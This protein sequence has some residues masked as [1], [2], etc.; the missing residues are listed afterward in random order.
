LDLATKEPGNEAPKWFP[1]GHDAWAFA[2]QTLDHRRVFK[3]DKTQEY[4]IEAHLYDFHEKPQ[5]KEK[6][7]QFLVDHPHINCEIYDKSEYHRDATRV[8][9]SAPNL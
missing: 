4:V 3:N 8:V 7:I 6:I 1:K 5:A 9:L 2:E